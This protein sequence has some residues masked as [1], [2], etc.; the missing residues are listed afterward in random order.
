MP[1][2]TR[3]QELRDAIADAIAENV[4]AYD[5]ADVCV[6]LFGLDPPQSV[7][8]DP[9]KSK[10]V[11]VRSRLM[12]KSVA[13]LKEIA[14]KVVEEYGDATLEQ[15]L[16][17]SSMTGVAGELKNLIFAANGPKPRIV[18]RDAIN[19]VI[20][21][22]ENAEFCLVYD[23]PLTEAGLSW[24]DLTAW[25]TATRGLK[26]SER[27]NARSLYRRL[28]QSMIGNDCERLVFQAYGE[29]YAAPN[30]FELPALIP[31]VYLHYDPYTQ[32][33]RGVPGPLVRQRMDFLLLLPQR[34]R[35]VV[36]VDG[37]QH[38]ADDNGR[39]APERYAE[40]MKED[41]ALRLAGYEVYRFGAKELMNGQTSRELARGLF[42]A[43]LEK[44]LTRTD[45]GQP[46]LRPADPPQDSR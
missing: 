35:I 38:Y 32:K 34:Q 9:Y 41:R 23:R 8:D 44:H 4:K 20:E 22:T 7:Y 33:E 28:D 11:Y 25:W 18:L 43:L 19:N 6:H 42:Q 5:V 2:A 10:R 46:R 39:A 3:K 27:E 24:R 1:N 21:I 36:E 12:Y 16:A 30:G 37:R 17:P 45:K 26:G 31:Q 29:L 15:L 14:G 13:D 40:M